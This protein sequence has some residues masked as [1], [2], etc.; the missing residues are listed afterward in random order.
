MNK[1]QAEINK[2]LPESFKW[3]FNESIT[4]KD[5]K[6]CGCDFYYCAEKSINFL[7]SRL[8]YDFQG[9][10]VSFDRYR[11]NIYYHPYNA[12]LIF[13]DKYYYENLLIVKN[14]LYSAPEEYEIFKKL[15]SD[16]ELWKK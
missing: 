12:S 11:L 3:F 5:N 4:T 1:A 9:K 8:Y 14:K 16:K 2:T 13:T 15:F 6:V 7:N 10:D